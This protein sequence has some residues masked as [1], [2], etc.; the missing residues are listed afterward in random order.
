MKHEKVVK[1]APEIN[2]ML[3]M[4][5]TFGRLL[6]LTET[7]NEP[8]IGWLLTLRDDLEL[9]VP[10]VEIALARIAPVEYMRSFSSPNEPLT[11]EV[12]VK[13]NWREAVSL[14]AGLRE[15]AT[16][17]DSVKNRGELMAKAEALIRVSSDDFQSLDKVP[18]S[19]H[20]EYA[21]PDLL[22][23]Y[24]A[25]KPKNLIDVLFKH[26]SH[27]DVIV[28]GIRA[29]SDYE[30]ELQMALMNRRLEPGIETVFMM[31]AESYS[32]V[33][34]RLVKEVF[35]LGG[36]VEGLVPPLVEQRMKEKIAPK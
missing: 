17:P 6:P 4:A 27:A 19:A 7:K 29:I 31:P 14:A 32:Y 9:N 13:T 36:T 28:R 8:L 15:I 2:E 1:D 30:Y 26:L 24:A 3:E 21:I 33:S 20:M 25:F 5:T 11:G 18:A 12:I 23:A 22:R 35:H 34:S 10:E 16:L